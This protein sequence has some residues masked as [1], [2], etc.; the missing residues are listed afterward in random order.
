MR[1]GEK[2]PSK[3]GNRCF[4]LRAV[5]LADSGKNPERPLTTPLERDRMTND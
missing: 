1:M 2:M 3:L 5:V 4:S